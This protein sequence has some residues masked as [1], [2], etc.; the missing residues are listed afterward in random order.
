MAVVKGK[1]PRARFLCRQMSSSRAASEAESCSAPL[2]MWHARDLTRKLCEER[3]GRTMHA[4][5]LPKPNTGSPSPRGEKR[6][7]QFA[8]LKVVLG[9]TA[10]Y[11]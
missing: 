9:V 1:P 8:R 4:R 5:A 11:I 7:S 3:L 10:I 2:T 6:R